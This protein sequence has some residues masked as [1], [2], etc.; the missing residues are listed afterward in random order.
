MRHTVEL[1]VDTDEV[2]PVT[3]EAVTRD[4]LGGMMVAAYL[5]RKGIAIASIKVQRPATAA[6]P[7]R[8][9][10]IG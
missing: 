5:K 6:A 1:Q 4:L 7:V 10:R 9:P 2:N 8:A 3:V